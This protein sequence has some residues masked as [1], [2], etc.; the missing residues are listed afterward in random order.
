MRPPPGPLREELPD[1]WSPLV[2]E[3][4][5]TVLA[6]APT[7]PFGWDRS[8]AQLP[9]GQDVSREVLDGHRE[10]RPTNTRCALAAEI[11]PDTPGPGTA[12]EGARTKLALARAHGFGHVVAATRPS[13]KE[14]YPPRPDRGGHLD[15]PDG[16][17]IDAWICVHRRL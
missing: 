10:G 11:A 7:G 12:S 9:A 14:G 2:G 17:C 3:G 5:R 15:R 8:D 13:W 6:E 1:V 4:P 16:L